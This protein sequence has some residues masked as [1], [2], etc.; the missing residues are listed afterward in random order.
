MKR[1]QPSRH[2][3]LK[4]LVG[5]VISGVLLGIAVNLVSNQLS[6]L[7][8]WWTLP[9]LVVLVAVAWLL[10]FSE[11]RSVERSEAEVVLTDAQRL[12]AARCRFAPTDPATVLAH[13][14][15]QQRSDVTDGMVPAYVERDIDADLDRAANEAVSGTTPMV[16]MG[17][18]KAGKTRSALE[19]IIRTHPGSLVVAP[20]PSRDMT[21]RLSELVAAASQAFGGDRPIVVLLDDLQKYGH[22]ISLGEI[23]KIAA[24]PNVGVAVTVHRHSLAVAENDHGFGSAELRSMLKHHGIELRREFSAAERSRAAEVLTS[25]DQAETAQLPEFLAAVGLLIEKYQHSFEPSFQG[26]GRE[27][28]Y[29]VAATRAVVDWARIGAG[30]GMSLEEIA[31]VAPLHIEAMAPTAIMPDDAELRRAVGWATTPVGRVHAL[32]SRVG[33]GDAQ[34]DLFVPFGPLLDVE[35]GP[36]YPE[37]LH[38]QLRVVLRDHAQALV[39]LAEQQLAAERPAEARLSLVDA[40]AANDPDASPKAMFNLGVLEYGAGN[41]GVARDWWGRAVESGHDDQAPKAMFNLGVLEDEAGN[42]DVAR[43]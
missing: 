10:E 40:L 34:R 5:L 24:L 35:P 42:V 43:D 20:E 27:A 26:T 36:G 38:P 28:L 21:L 41:V 32:V 31:L 8:L 3:A 1:P 4:R 33:R 12:V 11:R 17:D 14:L 15:P 6:A 7:S 25:I 22:A 37:R 19:A 2:T 29:G 23:E 39:S 16:V 30:P 13:R 18:P 9:V